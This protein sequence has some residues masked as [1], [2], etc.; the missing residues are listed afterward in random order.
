MALNNFKYNHLMPLHFKWLMY[1]WPVVAWCSGQV[2]RSAV[3]RSTMQLVRKPHR[4]RI[5]ANQIKCCARSHCRMHE[6]T[7]HDIVLRHT[8]PCCYSLT[9]RRL[10]GAVLHVNRL[11]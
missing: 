4:I 8:G 7:T 10:A 3:Q 5:I 1:T 6:S 9:R 2:R 11:A